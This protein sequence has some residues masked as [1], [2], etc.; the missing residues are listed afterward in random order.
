M[1]K[2]QRIDKQLELELNRIETNHKA[3]ETELESV[4][5]VIGQDIDNSFKTFS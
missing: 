3:I 1:K 4:Q 2:A 5:K